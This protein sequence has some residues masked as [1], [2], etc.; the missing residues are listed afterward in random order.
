MASLPPGFD[1]NSLLDTEDVDE[2]FTLEE[3]IASGSL[4]TVYK[5]VYRFF[6]FF[7]IV[8]LILSTLGHSFTNWKNS[9]HKNYNIR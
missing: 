1:F 8:L 2:I 7:P 3:E 9:S 5:V 4:G 6:F